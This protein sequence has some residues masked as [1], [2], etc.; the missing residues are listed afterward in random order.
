MPTGEET[1]TMTAGDVLAVVAATTVA[2]LVGLLAAS[3]VA[4]SST[5]RALRDTARAL[6]DEAVAL[7]HELRVAVREAATEVERVDRL[8]SSAERLGDAVDSAQ[9]VAYR[10]LASPVVKAMAFG[11]GVS[12]ARE[13]LRGGKAS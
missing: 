9:R 13:R 12:K 11:A 3:L 8:V 4:L 7:V 10:T 2:I 6:D 5:L 1:T